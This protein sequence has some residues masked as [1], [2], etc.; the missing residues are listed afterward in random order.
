MPA[1]MVRWREASEHTAV[2]GIRR[3]RRLRRLR[4]DDHTTTG[5]MR[6]HWDRPVDVMFKED[7]TSK[8][9]VALSTPTSLFYE[10]AEY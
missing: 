1:D 6:P 10:S 2:R 7:A 3:L 4:R 9:C 8:G 5:S